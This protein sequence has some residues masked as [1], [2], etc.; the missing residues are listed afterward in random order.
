[1]IPSYYKLRKQELI[2]EI[3]KAQAKKETHNLTD[4]TSPRAEGIL[5]ILPDG[6]DFLKTILIYSRTR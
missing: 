1:M 5:E 4:V 6:F 2:F 3:L